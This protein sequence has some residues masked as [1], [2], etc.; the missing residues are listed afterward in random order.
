MLDILGLDLF[1]TSTLVWE[2][3]EIPRR[4]LKDPAIAG[5]GWLF[6]DVYFNVRWKMKPP[7]CCRRW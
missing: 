6:G 7:G 1:Q 4:L 3:S 2:T 5:N